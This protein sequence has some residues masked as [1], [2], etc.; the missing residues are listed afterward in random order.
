M[1][2]LDTNVLVR[3]FA[4]DDPIHSATAVRLIE[5]RLTEEEPGYISVVALVET[6]WVLQ[7]RYRLAALDVA[8]IVEGLLE[9]PVV[10]VESAK[11]VFLAMT[12]VQDGRGSFSDVLIGALA[13]KAGCS[14]TVT[15]DR[16]AARLP[17]FSLA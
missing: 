7:R 13:A 10:V 9:A 15:F 5:H 17:G 8:R 2:G 4:Q 6:V 11:E 16:K 1:I 12:A 14:T 3:Y